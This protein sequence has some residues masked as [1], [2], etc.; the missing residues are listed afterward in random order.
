MLATSAGWI[1]S[2]ESQRE[3]QE[4]KARYDKDVI[5][6]KSDLEERYKETLTES[7]RARATLELQL[8]K[9]RQRVIGFKQA[10]A[11]QRQHLMEE[12]KQLQKVKPYI[13]P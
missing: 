5:K 11:S 7:R 8:E 2:R 4:F 9:E 3:I 6:I 13:V 10:M 1:W 12:R